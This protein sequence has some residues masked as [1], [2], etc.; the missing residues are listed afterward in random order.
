M[1]DKTKNTIDPELH[2]IFYSK[3]RMRSLGNKQNK[4]KLCMQGDLV[5]SLY[6]YPSDFHHAYTVVVEIKKGVPSGF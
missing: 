2:S 1:E 3:Y 4:G 6:P 5:S